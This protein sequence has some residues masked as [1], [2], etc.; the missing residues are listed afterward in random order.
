MEKH[1]LM[2]YADMKGELKDIRRRIEQGKKEIERLQRLVTADVVSCGKKGRKP[3]KTVKVEGRPVGMIER[4]EAAVRKQVELLAGLETE[5]AEKQTEVE[6]YIEQIEKSRMRSM[7][8]YYYIDDL[9]WEMVAM[10]MNYLYPKKRI[11]FTK[12]SCRMAHDRFLEKVL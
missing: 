11:S 2:E 7:F 6:E 4:K 9:T 5:F 1:I 12:D 8:R 3:L 10:K